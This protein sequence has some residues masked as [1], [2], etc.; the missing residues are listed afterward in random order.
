M[1][2]QIKK[3]VIPAGGMGTRFLPATKAL[4]KEMLPI[5]NIPAIHFIVSEALHAGIEDIII[6]VSSNKNSIIDYFDTNYELES[7]L[8]KNNK[9]EYYEMVRHISKM[10]NVHFIRQKEPNGLGDAI[11][12]ARVFCGNE[13]FGVILGDDIVFPTS[14]DAPNALAQCIEAFNKYHCPIVGTQRVAHDAVNK[15]GIIDVDAQVDNHVLSIKN[16]VEKPKKEDAPS[17]YAILGRYILTPDIFD[18][19]DHTLPDKSN[20]I[21]LTDALSYLL[22]NNKKIY[23]CV[24]EG[25]R[26]DVGSKLGSLKATNYLALKDSE[27]S[28][29]YVA[30]LKEIIKN[31][32]KK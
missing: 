25:Q 26:F 8:L 29:D 10:T 20:E 32:E 4:P 22:K 30:Y 2:A 12:C 13:P 28:Q 6:I 24:F 1:N 31:Y 18:A 3:L 11:R 27:I 5:L 17:D 7:R 23:A 15:Y 21:Q 9:L 19:I 14:Q 16:L